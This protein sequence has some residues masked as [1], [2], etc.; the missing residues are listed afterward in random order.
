MGPVLP[1]TS[2][3]TWLHPSGIPHF[4]LPIS[5]SSILKKIFKKMYHPIQDT[6]PPNTYGG[7]WGARHALGSGKKPG[8]E[9]E[10]GWV[11]S[12]LVRLPRGLRCRHPR[13]VPSHSPA[14]PRCFS[15]A[16]SH[17]PRFQ[18]G[19]R[20]LGWEG[21]RDWGLRCQRP[22]PLV[23]GRKQLHLCCLLFF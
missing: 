22:P 13:R 11:L 5:L 18:M 21:V 23:V 12:F 7:K 3:N 20:K 2:A 8:T 19:S 14:A 16:G 10:A 17:Q 6:P 9:K 15:A 1:K 4:I